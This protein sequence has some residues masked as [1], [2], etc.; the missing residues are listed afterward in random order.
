LTPSL[1]VLLGD[2]GQ[3]A[4]IARHP[5][6]EYGRSDFTNLNAAVRVDSLVV[7]PN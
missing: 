2:K 5:D 6:R 3:G 1:I 4:P 7:L